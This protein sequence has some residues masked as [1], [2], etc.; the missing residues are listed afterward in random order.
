MRSY[1]YIFFV[2]HFINDSLLKSDFL[3]PISHF[4]YIPSPSTNNRIC[5]AG[6]AEEAWSWIQRDAY[7]AYSASQSWLG[8]FPFLH[9]WRAHGSLEFWLL[10]L[11]I[12]KCWNQDYRS[13]NKKIFFFWV[14][15]GGGLKYAINLYRL[16]GKI[17]YLVILHNLARGLHFTN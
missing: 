8:Q 14:V 6:L 2:K 9:N 5:F 17:L 3:I 1:I 16:E 13:F 11:A 7:T 12:L 10:I 15:W 4:N